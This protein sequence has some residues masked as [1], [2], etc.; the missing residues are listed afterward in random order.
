MLIV[1]SFSMFES[2]QRLPLVAQVA[3]AAGE[4]PPPQRQRGNDTDAGREPMLTLGLGEYTLG[5]VPPDQEGGPII[6]LRFNLKGRLA[7]VHAT[8]ASN[9]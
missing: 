1:M 5:K 8:E 4:R 7:G 9:A 6:G 3:D 2:A